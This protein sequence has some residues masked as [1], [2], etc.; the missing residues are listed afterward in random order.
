MDA[1]TREALGAQLA[2]LWRR[3]GLTMVVATHSVEEAVF[4]G[5]TIAVL[6]GQP[7]K[8]YAVFKNF[9]T[10]TLKT[11]AED[12]FLDLVRDAR[13]ALAETWDSSPHRVGSVK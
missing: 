10:K 8:V 11:Y 6:G 9:R 7:T 2:Q 1:L 5:Q 4:L 3:L 12:Y 13:L